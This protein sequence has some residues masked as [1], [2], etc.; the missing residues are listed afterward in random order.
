VPKIAK[1]ILKFLHKP[2]KAVGQRIDANE[3]EQP[4][5]HPGRS[6]TA[7]PIRASSSSIDLVAENRDGESKYVRSD[8]L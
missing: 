8:T 4:Q 5:R 6:A 7:L 3:T 2:A 1:R